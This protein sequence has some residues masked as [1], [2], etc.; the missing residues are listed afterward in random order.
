MANVVLRSSDLISVAKTIEED[1]NHID[2]ALVKLDTVMSDLDSVW[3]D[4]NSRKY[5]ERYN[6]L[7]ANFPE[8]KEAVR[9]YGKFLETVVAEYQREFADP[10]SRSVNT[11]A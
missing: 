2:E 6:E 10:T 3:S 11:R 7:K 4:D 1:A 5:L 9:S 8:F